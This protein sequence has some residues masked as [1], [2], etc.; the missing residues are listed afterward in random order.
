MKNIFKKALSLLLCL[1]VLGVVAPLGAMTMKASAKTITQYRYNDVIEYGWYPQS[2]VLNSSTISKLNA[3]APA[4]NEWISFGYYSGSGTEADGK[5]TAK[6]YMRYVDVMLDGVKYRGVKFTSYRP[7]STGYQSY[8]TNSHTNQYYNGYSVQTISWFRYEPLK[9]CVLDSSSGLVVCQNI[10]DSQPYNNFVVNYGGK[11]YWGSTDL[12]D[13]FYANDYAKSSIRQ[14]LN[15]DFCKTAFSSAQQNNIQVSVLDNKA[16]DTWYSIFDSATTN[17]KIFLLSYEDVHNKKYGFSMSLYDSVNNEVR[18]AAGSDYAK[19]QGL[20]VYDGSWSRG[21]S[22]WYLRTPGETA[23]SA[24]FVHYD[25]SVDSNIYVGSTQV[26]VRPALRLKLTSDIIQSAISDVG[27]GVEAKHDMMSKIVY[28][29]GGSQGYVMYTCKNCGYSFKDTDTSSF[30]SV[31]IQNDFGKIDYRATITFSATVKNGASGAI[32]HW[33]VDGKDAGTGEK[34]TLKEVKKSFTIQAKYVKDGQIMAESEKE[35]VTVN[36]GF[37]AKLVAFFRA[38]F[39]RLPVYLQEYIGI[40][41][42]K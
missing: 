13:S 1:V 20:W 26:G 9:W 12:S 6:D 38:L 8:T 39:G 14:W 25:G 30:P 23:H 15:N 41:K 40:E 5:M 7:T 29:V 22:Y 32:V 33:F 36:T 17:D 18:K 2:E 21:N 27:V 34:L 3:Q 11:Y 42:A 24:C 19:C 35:Q 16:V 37:F 28:P 31:R 10:I 4:W